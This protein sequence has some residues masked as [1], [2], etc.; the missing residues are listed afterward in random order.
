L[1]D[2]GIP[3]LAEQ[4]KQIRMKAEEKPLLK[5]KPTEKLGSNFDSSSRHVGIEV[6]DNEKVADLI[7]QDSLKQPDPISVI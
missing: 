1:E 6:G 7:K 5:L 3:K 2:D 4:L